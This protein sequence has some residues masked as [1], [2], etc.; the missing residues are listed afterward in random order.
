[1]SLALAVILAF[2][3]EVVSETIPANKVQERYVWWWLEKEL[4]PLPTWWNDST[5]YDPDFGPPD[6][7]PKNSN[8]YD[9]PS[10]NAFINAGRNYGYSTYGSTYGGP[11][12]YLESTLRYVLA[13]GRLTIDEFLVHSADRKMVERYMR[14]V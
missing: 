1:M 6:H 5:S 10:W 12:T 13:G 7:K 2:T 8:P 9:D 3:I 11:P 4:P 14:I